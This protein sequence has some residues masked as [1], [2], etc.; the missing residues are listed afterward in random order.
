MFEFMVN[1]PKDPTLDEV[2]TIER[3]SE[4]AMTLYYKMKMPLC[5]ARDN[6]VRVERKHLTPDSQ[7]LTASSVTHPNYP[8]RKDVIRMYSFLSG[9]LRPSTE[10]PGNYVY[11]EISHFD[12]KG[13]IPVML[14]NMALSSEAA[15]SMKAV[16]EF[17]RK[18]VQK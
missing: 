7:F 11:S 5:T 13:S 17:M 2:T 12:M 4:D 16:A 14:L 1:P 6:I 9:W 3:N 8:I 18:D 10:R 15:A